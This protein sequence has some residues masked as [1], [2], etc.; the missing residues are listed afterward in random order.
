MS[1]PT[2]YNKT[3]TFANESFDTDFKDKLD[4]EFHN[5]ETTVDG[6][7]TN[8]ALVQRDDGGLRNGI[9]TKDSLS[10]GLYTEILSEI[11]GTDL[12]SVTAD[13]AQYAADAENSKDLAQDAQVIAEG[14]KNDAQ[15]YATAAEGYA[16][17]AQDA[18]DGLQV[19]NY[20]ATATTGQTQIV[21]GWTMSTSAKNVSVFIDNVPQPPSSFSLPN[22]TTILLS[23]AL[24]GGEDIWVKSWDWDAGASAAL[25]QVN[26]LSDLS[27]VSAART[28]LGL[29]T[30]A[31]ANVEDLAP[32]TF[33]QYAGAL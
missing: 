26:N 23:S 11:A 31:T 14:Y 16:Q 18:V 33:M 20:E 8:I 19:R 10:T 1:Q 15:G 30:A 5:V 27:D 25:Y 2:P 29:G 12:S 32:V 21:P 3:T 9:V 28:N 6:L 24:A 22:T 17:D 7:C 4:I 13:V